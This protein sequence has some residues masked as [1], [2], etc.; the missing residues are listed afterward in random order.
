MKHFSEALFPST[1]A[2]V[3]TFE[4]SQLERTW[5]GNLVQVQVRLPLANFSLERALNSA[6]LPY[7]W[8]LKTHPHRVI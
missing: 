5:F 3:L 4:L 2:T 6:W 7:Q 8:G 1:S